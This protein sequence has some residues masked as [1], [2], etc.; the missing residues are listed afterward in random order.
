V[1]S[2]KLMHSIQFPAKVAFRRERFHY[3]GIS[4]LG[5]FRSRGTFAGHGSS[6]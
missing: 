4:S 1:A 3:V 5:R 6:L 2:V